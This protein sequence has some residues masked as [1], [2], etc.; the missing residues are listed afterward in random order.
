MHMNVVLLITVVLNEINNDCHE[1]M[2]IMY[3]IED[4]L[5]IVIMIV[6]CLIDR[7]PHST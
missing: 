6:V 4:I 1:M 7:F 5:V 3:D 2:T